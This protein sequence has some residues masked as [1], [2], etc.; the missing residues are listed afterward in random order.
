MKKVIPF[1]VLLLA[2]CSTFT[3][4]QSFMFT[5]EDGQIIVSDYGN[6]KEKRASKFFAPNGKE[7]TMLSDKVV[8]VTLPD[9]ESFTAYE[10][11]NPLPIGTMYKSSN[12]KWMYHAAGISCQ[13]YRKAVNPRGEP[14]HE[15]VY[16]GIICQ[17]PQ[18]A[19]E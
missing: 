1:L 15:L 18:K 5:D 11:L 10:C 9:G 12:E 14:D 6:L 3:P 7:M 8:R 17:G 16:E 4:Q 2:G 13:V 19:A